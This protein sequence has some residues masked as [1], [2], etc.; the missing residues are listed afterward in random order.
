[1]LREES[2]GNVYVQGLISRPWR[3]A[4][5]IIS[6]LWREAV[7]SSRAGEMMASLICDNSEPRPPETTGALMFGWPPKE[8]LHYKLKLASHI[9]AAI[10]QRFAESQMATKP[11]VLL[12]F[13]CR[14]K[15][16]G[17]PFFICKSCYRGQCYC[18]PTC[19]EQTRRENQRENNRNYQKGFNARRLHAARQQDYRLRQ[20][21]IVTEQGS[22]HPS[23]SGNLGVSEIQASGSMAHSMKTKLE[24]VRYAKCCICGRR[25]RLKDVEAG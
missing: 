17:M 12:R 9:R 25:G 7:R 10:V 19:R 21:K 4:I 1:M 14:N 20:A 15:S 3:D 8:A 23:S 5:S 2:I 6:R 11:V 22:I 16:C 13:F 18:G 24:S